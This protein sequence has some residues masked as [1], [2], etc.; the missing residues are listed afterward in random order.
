MLAI[1]TVGDRRRAVAGP[2]EM[3]I[4]L[5]E[6]HKFGYEK[7]LWAKC[8]GLNCSNKRGS[9]VH[10]HYMC[11]IHLPVPSPKMAPTS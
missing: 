10:V 5:R 3:F 9:K 6:D 11:K 7:M 8:F 1:M 4:S 2:S